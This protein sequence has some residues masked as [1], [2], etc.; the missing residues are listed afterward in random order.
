[1]KNKKNKKHQSGSKILVALMIVAA[2]AFGVRFNEMIRGLADAGSIQAYAATEN[3]KILNLLETAAGEEKAPPEEK[4][5]S[6]SDQSAAKKETAN[7]TTAPVPN[8]KTKKPVIEPPSLGDAPSVKKGN[9]KAAD[10]VDD[11]YSD[12]KMEMFSD[13][14]KR[15]KDLEKKEKELI[16]R[17]ALIKA[18][19]AE[20]VQK[21]D[22][23]TKI[24]KDIEALLEQ[25]GIQENKRILSLVKIYE[26][27]KAKEAARI[28][29]SLETDVLLQVMTKMSERKSAPILAA[30]DPDKARHLTILLA[31]QNKLPDLPSLPVEQ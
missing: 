23:L 7:S 12:I 8:D 26:G 16:M 19:Q 21:T 6:A 27:M 15:R 9:W 17:E 11:E 10:D 5:K 28:F 3:E 31:E 4:L 14:S 18:A 30:M 24:K 25:Q 13:L 22:E 2:V 1:M 20:I 29:D